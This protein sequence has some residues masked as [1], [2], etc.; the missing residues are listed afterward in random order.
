[1]REPAQ[2]FAVD[3][4]GKDVRMGVK[5]PLIPAAS[6]GLP[7]V[8]LLFARLLFGLAKLRVQVAARKEDALSA[9]MKV[10]A[11]RS[12]AART[13]EL[14]LAVGEWL[15]INLIKGI[16]LGHGL[17]DNRLAIGRE[18]TFTRLDHPAS[19]LA[20]VVQVGWFK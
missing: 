9:W 8:F 3:V 16:T 13:H 20:D 2:I 7:I 10:R 17:V 15:C 12:A 5:I 6:A 18:V 1:M 4:G 11:G 19:D 14:C